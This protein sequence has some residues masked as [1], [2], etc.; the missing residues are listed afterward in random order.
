MHPRL[1][2]TLI[3]IDPVIGIAAAIRP[4]AASV[5][6]QLS[7]FRRDYWPSREEATASF[8]NSKFH[9]AWDK[10]VLDRWLEIGLRDIPTALYPQQGECPTAKP[11]T[12]STT[13]HHEVFT[14]LRPNFDGLD[15]D[16]HLVID[17]A[18]YP[19][20][21][22]DTGETYPFYR[23][24]PP[25]TFRRLPYVRPSVLY[26]F[27]GKSAVSTPELREARM[28]TTGIGVGGSGGARE[29]RVKEVLLEN[30]G[31]LIPMEA[32]DESADATADWLVQ[33]IDRRTREERAFERQ[34]HSKTKMQKQTVSE[35]WKE[36]VGGDPR[37][38][39][40]KPQL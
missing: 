20:L 30:I 5:L 28:Q 18:K 24:E 2:S 23:G 8:R 21:D 32:V 13:K 16:G 26:I 22:P 29:G 37:A 34:W 3:S 38:Q 9:Q 17:R 15:K 4:T 40:N 27:S 39:S 35:E 31:H 11:V 7:T 19:D 33:E 1:L 6:A 25:S 10:R 36:R 12:L 14:F